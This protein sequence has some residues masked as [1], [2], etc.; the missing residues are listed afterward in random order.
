MKKAPLNDNNQA[1]INNFDFFYDNERLQTITSKKEIKQGL[2]YFKDHRVFDMDSDD[3]RLWAYVDDAQADEPY[4]VEL[5]HGEIGQLYALCPC[6]TSTEPVCKHAVA[7]LYHYSDQDDDQSLISA[8][9]AAIEERIKKGKNEV[10]VSHVSGQ[11][12][13]G[14][15]T[16]A[17]IISTTHHKQT[18]QVHIRSLKEKMN[19]C[20]CPDY[21][22]NLLGTCKHI[23]AVLHQISKTK[24]RKKSTKQ[25]HPF[26]YL[27]WDV[28]N[29]PQIKVHRSVKMAED[30]SALINANFDA[31][32][33]FSGQIPDDYFHLS[34]QCHG[35]TDIQLGED[36]QQFVFRHAESA[37]HQL[38]ASVIRNEI[39]RSNGVLKGVSA[40]LYPYQIEGVAFLAASGR[41]LLADD[42]GLGKTLQAIAAASWL[43]NNRHSK[44][45][46]V[47]CPASLKHQWAREI[48]RFTQLQVSIIQGSPQERNTQYRKDC[49]FFIINYELVLRDLSQINGLLC[50]DLLILDEAQRIKN[51][52]TKIASSIK[53]ISSRYAFVLSGT[54]LENRLEDLYSL[55][56]VIDNQILGPLWRYMIDFHVTDDRG[57]VLGYRNL[58]ELRKRIAPVM[59]RR[60]R[61]LVKNQLPEMIKTRLDIPMTA[62][63]WEI[64]DASLAAA[65]RLGNIAKSRPL[66][67]TER[68][69]LMSALQQARMA[70]DAAGLVDDSIIG[71]PKLDELAV[72]V[73]EICL[74]NGRKMVVFSQWEKMTAM[75]EKVI[76]TLKVGC[77]RLHGGVPTSKRGE[78]IERFRDDDSISVFISTDAGGVGL[79][80]QNASFLVNLDIPWNP[81]ILEQ[82]N[83][84]VHRLG[85][86][87]GVQII[88]MV[89]EDSYEERVL[90]LIQN[91]Q[92]LFDNVIAPEATEDVV[93]V[94]KDML[95]TIMA[96]LLPEQVSTDI[97]D[98]APP[99]ENNNKAIDQPHSTQPLTDA[100]QENECQDNAVK[101]CIIEIQNSFKQRLERILGVNGGLLAV[102][103]CVNEKDEVIAISLSELIPVALIDLRTLNGLQRLGA[104]SP[105]NNATVLCQPTEESKVPVRSALAVMAADKLQAAETLIQ[106]NML[107]AAIELMASAMLSATADLAGLAQCPPAEEVSLWLFTV[108]VPK[109]VITEALANTLLLAL[110]LKNAASIP[111][112]LIFDMLEKVKLVVTIEP[113]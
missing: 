109:G 96:E 110:S 40:K 37:S 73:D 39:M 6:E 7:V 80:L 26:V 74:Q 79:N 66:T 95:K 25:P 46:L 33:H 105:L 1:K 27:A 100:E 60:E 103:D 9:S 3:N 38:K 111:E 15:W 23:E 2:A 63:Q 48:E 54:P 64:H 61:T 82:R 81:A 91:K 92:H 76:K 32:G 78:L 29:A 113:C 12:W 85:Q 44:K 106:Q 14:I 50:P 99:S 52:R 16:A 51:W 22:T 90:Q 97:T 101:Q 11:P 69:Q 18:Y 45:T 59:L 31:S 83:A 5:T 42:M 70:C 108:A 34:D 89:A 28:E 10:N 57:K 104:S 4:Y 36:A 112:A 19:Y 53:L 20:T 88:L 30:L 67:P 65:A 107:T 84:R 68:N 75:A 56:Q 35:R 98:S 41:A 17:S 47:I 71:S 93:G 55:M 24:P 102:L 13:F 8:Q 43:K 72:L 58:S 94:D 62:P 49:D 77:V 87:H 86:E 21:A